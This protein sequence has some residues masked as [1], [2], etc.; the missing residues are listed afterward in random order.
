MENP[1]EIPFQ[2]VLTALLDAD[3]TLNPR[4]LYR[5]S[6]LDDNDLA[7][8]KEN[9]GNMPIWRRQA[10]M[11]DLEDLGAADNLLSFEAIGRHAV[12]DE[13]P[14]VREL[15][16]RVL[17]EFDAQDLISIYLKLLDGDPEAPVRA[18]AATG[19]GQYVYFGE[20]DELPSE[21]V[22]TI[23]DQLL[24]TINQ[25][26]EPHVRQRALESLSFASREEIPPLIEK[27]F[28][29]GDPDW[30]EASL[31]AMGRSMD[32]RWNE[33]VLEMLDHTSP[34]LRAEA[35]RAAGELEIGSAL[36]QLVELTSD[37]NEDV[38]A[39][40]IWSLSQIGGDR[41]RRTLENLLTRSFEDED[42]ELLESALD[43]LAFNEGMQAFALF[44]VSEE[45]DDDEYYDQLL[46][47]EEFLDYTEEDDEDFG[48]LPYIEDYDVDDEDLPD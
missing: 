46:E 3:T 37:H 30:M 8:L 23:G 33:S 47:D 15:G 43:N 13:D 12:S 32:D 9:W 29:S 11:E 36:S 42:I 39:A 20:L 22:R 7:L 5:L 28:E 44:E 10:L 45:A 27:A 38:R 18:A 1:Q 6:D 2:T 35:A 19:L 21:R 16:V 34:D 41:A 25:D 17:W 14:K 40:A 31:V 48:E 26:E 24:R 4:Y